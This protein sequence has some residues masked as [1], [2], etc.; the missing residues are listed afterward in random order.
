MVAAPSRGDARIAAWVAVCAALVYL[1]FGHGH[2]TGSDEYGVYASTEALVE[3]GDLA[4][5]PGLHRFAGRDGRFYSIF[6]PGQSVLAV[7]F[8]LVGAWVG[9]HVPADAISRVT[10]RTFENVVDTYE[11]PRI[12]AVSLYPPL[13]SALLVALFYLFERRLGASRRGALAATALLGG[14]TY[15]ALMSMYF[16]RHTTETLAI[17]GSLYALYGWRREGRLTALAVGCLLASST[18]LIRVPSAVSGVALAGYLL[19]TL[20]ERARAPGG[21]PAWPR[22]LLAV[23]LPAAAVAAAHM[24]VNHWKWGTWLA[25]PM[26][27]QSRAFSTPLYIGAAGLL[28]APGSSLFVYS[29]LLCLL[30]W[31]LPGFLRRHRAEAWTLLAIAGSLLLLSSGFQLW[32]GLWSSP[33]PRMIFPAVPLLMLP[34]GPWLDRPA[35]AARTAAVAALACLGAV[36]QLGL[37]LARWR[38]IVDVMGYRSFQPMGSFLWSPALSPVLG[39]WRVVARGEVDTWLWS[40]VFGVP[41]REPAPLVATVLLL[42]WAVALVGAIF[43]LRRSLRR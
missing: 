7:P 14:T 10:G 20:H 33:G 18:V 5:G 21:L 37:L 23:A 2:L 40:L 1:P 27:D 34:L 35:R 11:N 28:F 17:L 39:A 19:F 36:V 26:L 29:P 24:G 16:L 4:V 38:T 31:T 8:Y 42:A 15:V 43:A 41:G 22:L 6:A 32:H 12:F 3:R 9:E 25:S 30:P 13:A